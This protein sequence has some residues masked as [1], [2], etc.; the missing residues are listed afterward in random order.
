MRQ[1]T[2]AE[3]RLN[4]RKLHIELVPVFLSDICLKSISEFSFM[5]DYNFQKPH[6]RHYLLYEFQKGITVT[7]V[8]ENISA[9]YR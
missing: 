6:I 2:K 5:E 3:P 1:P 7:E 9:V 4:G 8:F